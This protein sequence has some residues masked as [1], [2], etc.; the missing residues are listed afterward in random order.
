M[1]IVK[2]ILISIILILV[3][4]IGSVSLCDQSAFARMKSYTTQKINTNKPHSTI[5]PKSNIERPVPPITEENLENITEET[6]KIIDEDVPQQ[7]GPTLYLPQPQ[8]SPETL[9]LEKLEVIESVEIVVSDHDY[10]LG[11]GDKI[12]ITVFG[13][14]DLSGDYKIGGDGAISIPL[15]GVVN[16]ADMNLRQAEQA[17]EEKLLNG[18]LKTP[19]VSIEVQESRPFYIMGEVRRPG[20][21]N[22][23][24]GMNILQ[25]VA[26]SGG[27]TYRANRKS[28]DV[29]RGKSSPSKPV[30]I[31]P[32]DPVRAGDI[33]FVRERFF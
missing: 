19:S 20:S 4:Q 12:K 25:A 18:Y 6:L 9:L 17:I 31:S 2:K 33:I 28:V 5:H 29:I 16:V 13:E 27:F 10:I 8:S 22:Y 3:F 32:D 1:M 7:A 23:I 26:I 24:N 30:A 14:K 15:I 21:Y 11:A